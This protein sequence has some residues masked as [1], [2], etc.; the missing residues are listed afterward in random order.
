MFFPLHDNIPAR[1]SPVV[2]Y[3]LVIVNLSVFL[4][5]SGLPS[6]PQEL[7]AY[8]FGFVPARIGQLVH[9]E[10][11]KVPLN[12]VVHDDFRGDYYEQVALPLSPNPWQIAISLLTCMFLHGGWLHLLTNMWFLWLFGDNVEDRLGHLPY[13][14]LYLAGGLIASLANWAVTPGS[15][16]P[17]IGASGAIAGILG[18]YAVTWPFA[19]ISTFVVLII[20]FT[21]IDVPALVVLGVWFVAQI[22]AGQAALHHAAAGG[23]AWWAHVGGFL[24]GMALM[25]PLCALFAEKSIEEEVTTAVP[26]EG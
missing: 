23:V 1:R 8:R 18:A 5:V 2:T 25:P 15:L 20:F 17:V 4:W 19:R 9:P 21:V 22:M 16:T 6:L 13:L 11:I 14:F 3:L 7:I 10:T 24:A 12:V 26:D